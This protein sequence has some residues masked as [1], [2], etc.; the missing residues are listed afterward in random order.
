[1]LILSIE[2]PPAFVQAHSLR[3]S[4][5]QESNELHNKL[6]APG[7]AGPGVAAGHLAAQDFRGALVYRIYLDGAVGIAVS[8][9]A[10]GHRRAVDAGPFTG[11]WKVFRRGRAP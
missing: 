4:R 2:K 11:H 1:M 9:C 7:G 3:S 5:V 10:R 8:G 6:R